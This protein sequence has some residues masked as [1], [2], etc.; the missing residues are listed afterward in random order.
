MALS[1]KN[2]G[3]LRQLAVQLKEAPRRIQAQAAADIQRGIDAMIAEEFSTKRGP[4]GVA[5]KPPR[6]GGE[7]MVRT[8][9]LR[10]G[11][12]V[13]VVK[14]GTGLSLRIS[15][16]QAYA[17]WLQSGTASVMARPMV[18]GSTIPERWKKIFYDSYDS[19]ISS[20]WRSTKS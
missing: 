11:F 12:R 2:S 18:P 20:W 6:D 5:W 14:S 7:T 13:E 16:S 4:D 9:R 10:D 15:N 3:F 1:V 17:K 19:A 8:G